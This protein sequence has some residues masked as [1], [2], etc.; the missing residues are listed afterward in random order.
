MKLNTPKWSP[1]VHRV[2]GF[3]YRLVL[4]FRLLLEGLLAVEIGRSLLLLQFFLLPA[5]LPLGL[6][7]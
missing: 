6:I 7:P 3:F 4:G 1:I 5:I 2:K